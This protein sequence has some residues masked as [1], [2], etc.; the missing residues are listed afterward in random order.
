MASARGVR[1]SRTA[2]KA[3]EGLEQRVLDRLKASLRE[4]AGDPLLGKKLKGD[5]EGLRSYRLGT[6]RI[7]YR[8][9][10]ELVEIIAIDHRKDV[11]R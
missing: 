1:L 6:Y 9:T 11:Y 8:F 4:L 2:E 3:L 7:V 5:F 10:R